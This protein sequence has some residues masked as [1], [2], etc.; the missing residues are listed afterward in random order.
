VFLSDQVEPV[1]AWT[2]QLFSLHLRYR[3][4]QRDR[5]FAIELFGEFAGLL[6][7]GEAQNDDSR[8]ERL[9]VRLYWLREGASTL[10]EQPRSFE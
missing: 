10:T 4:T 8:L 9:L 2:E 1:S 5:A 3:A 6:A 7:L